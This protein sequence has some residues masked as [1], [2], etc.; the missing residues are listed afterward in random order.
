MTAARSSSRRTRRIMLAICITVWAAS[1]AATH[2]PIAELPSSMDVSDKTLHAMGYFVL[3]AAFWWTLLVYGKGAAVRAGATAIVMAA[4]GVLDEVT[5][6][7]TNAWFHRWGRF[8]DWL[9]D[10]CGIVIAV[11]VM[12]SFLRIGLA[13]R[14]RRKG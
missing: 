11:A 5:Q 8:D 14:R 3:S 7:L 6:Q 4:Y 13:V 12:Q 1:F 2:V 9:A 10:L